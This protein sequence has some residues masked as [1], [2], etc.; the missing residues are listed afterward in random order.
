MI[1]R[2]KWNFVAVILAMFSLILILTLGSSYLSARN[3]ISRE[4]T[5]TLSTIAAQESREPFSWDSE[6][7]LIPY[8]SIEVL[9]T[10]HILS[11]WDEYYHLT[12]ADLLLVTSLVLGLDNPS[13]TL[14][15]LGIRY[16]RQETQ[17]GFRI[18]CSDLSIETSLERD[19]RTSSLTT[20]F[21][22]LLALGILSVM[23]ANHLV[24]PIETAWTQ[25][26]QFVADA[27]HE[28]K[29]PLTVILSSA[30]LLATQLPPQ[31]TTTRWLEN[32]QEEGQRMRRLIED[33]L[34]LTHF[35]GEEETIPSAV[36]LSQLLEHS[37]LL[38]QPIAF[39]KHLLLEDQIQEGL[40]TLGNPDRLQQLLTI[41]LDNSLKYSPSHQ[42]IHIS[43]KKE[44]SK[45][46]LLQV[47][48]YS[49]AMSP[50]ECAQLFHRFYRQD[51]SRSVQKGYGLGLSIAQSIVES[52]GGG[53]NNGGGKIWAEYKDQQIHFFVRLPL[54]PKEK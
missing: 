13:G 5:N 35:Q 38:F 39:E 4:V 34:T 19:L 36:D 53:G 54:P 11:F 26:R 31:E 6:L 20:G 49:P 9:N 32:I 10:G 37:I 33:M 1:S 51:S 28:L 2:L 25:Q 42:S 24:R 14:P 23:L 40:V 43:L 27:S 48:N 52:S 7:L 21:F 44:S 41:L 50:Q 12:E 16:V 15:S 47:S 8:F 17:R 18:V 22:S 3:S 45:Y 30:E 29:T 46:L